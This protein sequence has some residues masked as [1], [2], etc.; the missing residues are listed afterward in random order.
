MPGPSV[1]TAMPLVTTQG[2]SSQITRVDDHCTSG[3]IYAVGQARETE[4]D[5]E[6]A[7]G[8]HVLVFCVCAF[9]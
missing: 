8:S 6:V 3:N 2:V 9:L 5:V 7:V 4:H 1:G